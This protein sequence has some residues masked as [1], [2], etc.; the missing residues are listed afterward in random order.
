MIFALSA[1][2][3]APTGRTPSLGQDGILPGAGSLV[4]RLETWQPLFAP[5]SKSVRSPES[6]G[7]PRTVE[8]GRPPRTDAL[9]HIWH[10]RQ[11]QPRS[12][13]RA[14]A[15]SPTS[16]WNPR[17][18]R[19][20]VALPVAFMTAFLTAACQSSPAPSTSSPRKR[21]RGGRSPVNRLNTPRFDGRPTWWALLTAIR[22][23]CSLWPGRR[24][25]AYD[26]DRAAWTRRR[27]QSSVRGDEGTVELFGQRD[28]GRVVGADV[29]AEFVG[30]GHEGQ[31]WVAVGR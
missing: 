25:S 30:A 13:S 20:R 21:S 9:A 18:V 31:R 27:G 23:G 17:T 11:D 7:S 28:V 26:G 14:R 19:I 10:V 29:R 5:A 6:L 4:A 22:T 3:T 12:P 8:P 2:R 24:S 1:D 16:V 15:T